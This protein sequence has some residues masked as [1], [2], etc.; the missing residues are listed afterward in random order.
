MNEMKIKIYSPLCKESERTVMSCDASITPK[1]DAEQ[2][3]SEFDE[4]HCRQKKT[5]ECVSCILHELILDG[6]KKR[7][8]GHK[9]G[10][11][12]DVFNRRK[13]SPTMPSKEIVVAYVGNIFVE[14]LMEY[15]CT[16]AVLVILQRLVKHSRGRFVLLIENWEDVFLSCCVLSN[17]MLDDFHMT[18]EDYCYFVQDL[19]LARINKIELGLL[20]IIDYRCHVPPSAY[21]R[22]HSIVQSWI[23]PPSGSNDVIEASFRSECSNRLPDRICDKESGKD[24]TQLAATLPVLKNSVKSATKAFRRFASGPLSHT[25]CKIHVKRTSLSAIEDTT[26]SGNNF[27]PVILPSISV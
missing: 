9:N 20:T 16:V 23:S 5:I 8:E 1:D 10:S 21:S 7:C 3:I 11:K 6:E 26:L 22:W 24:T 18:N 27:S 14:A 25:K 2:C 15:E 13:Q 19:T 12:Y 17:K 4:N